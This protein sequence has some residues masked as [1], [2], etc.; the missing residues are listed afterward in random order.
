MTELN[1]KLKIDWDEDLDPGDEPTLVD[2]DFTAYFDPDENYVKS[3]TIL[4]LTEAGQAPDQGDI[5]DKD[6]IIV[7]AQRGDVDIALRYL[8]GIPTTSYKLLRVYQGETFP[9]RL[10]PGDS[11]IAVMLHALPGTTARARVIVIG[12]V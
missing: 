11:G 12:R 2:T 1:I 8:T 4:E 5:S 7:R 6:M 9:L 3:D 10:G